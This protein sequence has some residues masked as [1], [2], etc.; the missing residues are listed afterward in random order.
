MNNYTY[1]PHNSQLK[2]FQAIASVTTNTPAVAFRVPQSQNQ[3]QSLGVGMAASSSH[4]VDR[5][6]NE[7]HKE[8]NN[9]QYLK[10]VKDTGKFHLQDKIQEILKYTTNRKGEK[11][12]SSISFCGK[13]VIPLRDNVEIMF[14]GEKSRYHGLRTCRNPHVCPHCS[15]L[16]AVREAERLSKEIE[17][18]KAKGYFVYLLTL[19][20]SHKLGEPLKP[21]LVDLSTAYQGMFR[22]GTFKKMLKDNGLM[23]ARVTA[24]EQTWGEKNGWHPHLH[25]VQVSERE[26]SVAEL[27]SLR[28]KI[29]EHWQHELAKCG[30]NCNKNNGV[31]FVGG[32]NASRYI[33]KWGLHAELSLSHKKQGKNGSLN[34]FDIASL[35][36]ENDRNQK[37]TKLVIEYHAATKGVP[38]LNRAKSWEELLNELG[39]EEK[40]EK[41]VEEKT[42]ITLDKQEFNVI[43]KLKFRGKAL[44]IATQCAKFANR[45]QYIIKEIYR[46]FNDLQLEQAVVLSSSYYREWKYQ[47]RELD[48][49]R[50]SEDLIYHFAL[51]DILDFVEKKGFSSI[52]DMLERRGYTH[53]IA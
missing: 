17:F 44:E 6:T 4:L 32:E 35:S 43:K 40:E 31:T 15:E 12:R 13:A 18:L 27:L 1:T 24:R 5:E 51:G 20:F 23:T 8:N 7:Q 34:F 36:D 21:M 47:Y 50:L 11:V 48:G 37:F 2:N 41:V 3:T 38:P 45:E 10:T 26:L 14:N 46:N 9:L 25:I 19:T 22:N 39:Y 30:R 33:S 16:K 52:R 29:Y 53:K 49:S 28:E 42:L